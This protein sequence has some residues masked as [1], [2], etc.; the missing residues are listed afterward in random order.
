MH[1]EAAEE[2]EPC[3]RQALSSSPARPASC[4]CCRLLKDMRKG[5]QQ[6]TARTAARPV[7]SGQGRAVT[8]V[9]SSEE[10]LSTKLNSA[11]AA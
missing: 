9:P 6:L 8:R 7:L 10:R 3:L 11:T 1:A 4:T 5:L 2:K